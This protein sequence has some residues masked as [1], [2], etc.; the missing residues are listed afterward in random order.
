MA[1]AVTGV[2]PYA[3][4]EFGVGVVRLDGKKMAKSTGNLVLV[5]DVLAEHPAAALRLCLIDRPWAADW[6]YSVAELDAATQRLER[7][8]QAAGRASASVQQAAA[9]A[10][11]AALR[12]DL[13]VPAALAVA[14]EAGGAA[15]RSLIATLGLSELA[16]DPRMAHGYPRLPGR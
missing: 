2:S 14:E 3:R 5:T 16:Q 9:A 8:Y 4:A 6:D 13:D 1:E 10:I 7:L 12:D 11:N 15:A